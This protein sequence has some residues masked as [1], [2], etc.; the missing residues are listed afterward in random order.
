LRVAITLL[1]LTLVACGPGG[2]T[3]PSA[4]LTGVWELSYSTRAAQACAPPA[5]P[6]LFAGCSGAGEMTLTQAGEQIDGTIVFRGG[7]QSCGS[8]ADFFGSAA[9]LTGH[10]RADRLELGTELCRYE[11]RVPS[12]ASEVSGTAACSYEVETGGTWRMKRR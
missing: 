11:A 3:Q 9:P 8:A 12:D 1:L 2:V 10:L 6:D 4:D 5:P 7:C